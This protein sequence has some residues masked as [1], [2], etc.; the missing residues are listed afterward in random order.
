MKQ[1]GNFRSN[2]LFYDYYDIYNIVCILYL[3][4]KTA[5][6]KLYAVKTIT[7]KDWC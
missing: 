6:V 5:N 4:F 1:N 3:Q 2:A 7:F